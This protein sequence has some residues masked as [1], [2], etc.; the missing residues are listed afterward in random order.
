M[1]LFVSVIQ[2]SSQ[3][4]T[5]AWKRTIFDIVPCGHELGFQ[6]IHFIGLSRAFSEAVRHWVVAVVASGLRWGLVLMSTAAHYVLNST[7][8][9]R[10]HSSGWIQQH[11]RRTS[12]WN[13]ETER[14]DMVWELPSFLGKTA[15]LWQ[16]A[17]ILRTQT[18][19]QSKKSIRSCKNVLFWI[20]NQISGIRKT[21]FW[22]INMWHPHLHN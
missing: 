19:P 13:R 17:V 6:A 1:S 20:W 12:A 11:Y 7:G 22:S 21:D 5:N 8:R 18:L 14:E 4:V 10:V 9:H 15:V 16:H 3:T 2:T